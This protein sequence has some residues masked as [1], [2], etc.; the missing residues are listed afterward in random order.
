MDSSHEQRVNIKFC[1]KL[2]RTFAETFEMI[3]SV[4]GD[5]SLSRTQCYEW[6]RRFK[7]GR[8]ST[9]DNHRS[10]RPSTSTDASHVRQIDELV[11]SNRRLTVREMSV[12][13][14]ISFG[15]CQNILTEHLGM[16]RIA[17]KFVPRLLTQEQKDN[18]VT[19]CQELL[20]RA[21]EEE[22]FMETVVTGDETWVFGYDVETKVQSSQWTGKGSPRPK[23][24]RQVRSSVKVM[25]TV[26]FDANGVIHHEFLPQGETVNRFY[27]LG[28]LR[29][30][31]ENIRRKRPE[32][33]RSKSWVLHH[34]NAPAHSSLLIRDYCAKSE[35]TVLPQPPYSPDLA[36]ADFFLFPKLKSTLKGRRFDS[37]DAI[38]ESSLEQLR[39][40]PKEAYKSAFQSWKHRWQRCVVSKGEYFE[41]DTLE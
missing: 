19:I 22:D 35:T 39:A 41:G 37:I 24:A 12:D 8:E 5:S 23:K 20:D 9:E 10:G 33:W 21:N 15:S 27:Y 25:L 36:P 30:L 28:V 3:T 34:D 18:R 32:L 26:F 11:H 17:A 4:Y 6:F 7:N 1:Y 14:D 31:R 13:C 2:G 38:K 16:R 40:I 29:R